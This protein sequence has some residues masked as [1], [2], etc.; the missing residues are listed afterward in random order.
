MT[1]MIEGVIHALIIEKDDETMMTG[2]AAP[3][4]A[5]A[6]IGSL[7]PEYLEARARLQK[8]GGRGR[9]AAQLSDT[10][11]QAEEGGILPQFPHLLISDAKQLTLLRT[12]IVGRPLSLRAIVQKIYQQRQTGTM[13]WVEIHRS[14]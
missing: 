9:D 2:A 13:R 6:D 7:P 4:I 8:D 10:H 5:E 12:K 11:L 14:S 3:V 1:L